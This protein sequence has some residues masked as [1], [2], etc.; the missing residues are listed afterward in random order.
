MA[1]TTV[2]DAAFGWGSDSDE[3]AAAKGEEQPAA[4]SEEPV[5]ASTPPPP[6]AVE[7]K[8]EDSGKAEEGDEATTAAAKEEAAAA[9]AAATAAKAK[10]ESDERAAAA[11][12]AEAE[13]AAAAEQ[14]VQ[15]EAKEE[16]HG[17]GPHAATDLAAFQKLLFGLAARAGLS[18]T[19]SIRLMYTLL[20]IYVLSFVNGTAG[21]L[22]WRFGLWTNGLLHMFFSTDARF[23]PKKQP[24]PDLVIKA[25]SNDLSE[26]LPTR[27]VIFIR[28]GESCWNEAP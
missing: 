19:T 2:V 13:V 12:K 3:G 11:A 24:D 16:P 28:H 18:A 20:A 15:D 14:T 1:T 9:E 27:R 17:D 5:A 4:K 10:A 6:P 21:L 8:E 26:H 25:M 22:W 7:E 23:N